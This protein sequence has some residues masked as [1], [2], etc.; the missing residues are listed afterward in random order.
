M[1]DLKKAG[2]EKAAHLVEKGAASQGKAVIRWFKNSTKKG[3]RML[4]KRG[5]AI[6]P[7]SCATHTLETRKSAAGTL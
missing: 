5:P 7:E 4:D 1:S 3:K 6:S 2:V